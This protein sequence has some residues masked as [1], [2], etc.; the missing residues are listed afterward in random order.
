MCIRDRGVDL[1][2]V[3]IG[4]DIIIMDNDNITNMDQFSDLIS[5]GGTVMISGNENLSNLNG[6]SSLNFV[7][8]GF[9]LSDNQSL[10]NCCGIYNLLVNNNISGNIN[11]SNNPFGCSS[12]DDII[13]TCGPQQNDSDNDGIADGQDNCP[14]TPN[15]TQTDID[16]D[17][18]GEVCD[19]NDNDATI[20]QSSEEIADGLDNDCDGA[21]DLSIQC[22]ENIVVNIPMGE[23]QTNVSWT[24][25]TV[26]SH[27]QWGFEAGNTG[28]SN[29]G[30]FSLGSTEII[31][32][33]FDGCG[34]VASCTFTVTVVTD[35]TIICPEN[36]VWQAAPGLD[37]AQVDWVDPVT[38]SSCGGI[39]LEQIGGQPRGSMYP[40]GWT[41]IAYR[42]TDDCNNQVNCDFCFEVVE[43]GSSSS[44]SIVSEFEILYLQ[45]TIINVNQIKLNWTTNTDYRTE[46]YI[47]E[48]SSNG[49]DFTP[50]QNISTISQSPQAILYDVIDD[51]PLPGKNFYRIHR[52]DLS[53]SV[54]FSNIVSETVIFQEENFTI[55]P[56]PAKDFVYLNLKNYEG[57]QLQVQLTN[58]LGQIIFQ[59][60]VFTDSNTPLSI[61]ISDFKD[62]VYLVSVIRK[63][64]PIKSKKL[65]IIK[66]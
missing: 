23:T 35:L 57:Q 61:P 33:V 55:F 36:F 25:A 58:S 10:S 24:P 15:S 54:Q 62:G 8:N 1:P 11:I 38:T 39:S 47:I 50:I 21:I 60:K 53:T 4:D 52:K 13:L 40:I 43:Y 56:N 66:P 3:D 64:G 44:S 45:S 9:A 5:V 63:N 37:S 2:L 42:A 59:D 6:F 12:V 51:R 18:F 49:I 22:Q 29:G 16:G 28:P 31:E 32:W 19:C 46:Q 7:G 34:E 20:N 48:R 14:E 65:V 41:C 17:G 27:C 30:I 26:I